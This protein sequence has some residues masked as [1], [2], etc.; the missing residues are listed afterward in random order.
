MSNYDN[1]MKK[2]YFMFMNHYFNN[3]FEPI[4]VT[5][6]IGEELID[7]IKG[8]FIEMFLMPTHTVYLDEIEVL[9][10]DGK[11]KDSF[12][13]IEVNFTTFFMSKVA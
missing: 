1:I 6:M 8:Q 5:G 12:N 10:R 4:E 9:V 3:S 11:V 2:Q 13:D 7:F